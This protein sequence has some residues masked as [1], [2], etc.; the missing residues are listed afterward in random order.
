MIPSL[1]RFRAHFYGLAS[2]YL[3]IGGAATQLLLDEAGLTSRAT[4]A[5]DI[6]PCVEALDD[7]LRPPAPNVHRSC[8]VQHIVNM[9]EGVNMVTG[10]GAL[11]ERD[12]SDA[13]RRIL[14]E[15]SWLQG[16]RVETGTAGWDLTASG[17][18]ASGGVGV[19]CVECKGA[20]FQP[21]QFARIAERSCT[22]E[23]AASAKVL[24]M[25]RVSSRMTEMC[26][27]HGWG[28]FDL[29][30]NCWLEVPDH[31]LIKRSGNDPVS[32][33]TSRGVNLGTPKAA[34]VI[35]ALLAPENAGKRWTQR[36][37]VSH[38]ADADPRAAAPS[39]AL[40]N[41]VVQHLR[42][43]AFIETLPSRGFRVRDFDGLLQTWRKAY[44][45]DRHIR[46][47]YFTLLPVKTMQ[48]RIKGLAPR[49]SN[50]YAYAVFTAA[51]LQA[52]AVRQPRTWLYVSPDFES[53]LAATLDAKL[54]DS[55]EN[56]VALI[57]SDEG[58]FYRAETG[59]DGVPR[60]NPVQTYVDVANAGQ[61]GDEAAEAI[62]TQRLKSAWAGIR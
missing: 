58:V 14:H 9:A 49:G 56:I 59:I 61:R 17:P 10:E 37:L 18:L 6:V 43:Q 41:G 42:D 46:R 60:T 4:K 26:R 54:V 47:P 11:L 40:V 24:A 27:Q 36:E 31:F 38:F 29:A 44:R 3:L 45:F 57:P 23:N 33:R 7:T 13:L 62:L 5:L 50:R 39:L 1:D 34:Q 16:W 19:L 22:S 35:R 32:L 28:W 25:P 53:E 55:G 2:S 48:E 51:D 20:N 8:Y 15:A 12:L 52:P 30:G 21:G